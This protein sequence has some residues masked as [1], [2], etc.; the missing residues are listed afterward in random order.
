MSPA[1]LL[2]FEAANP[3]WSSNKEM[4][5]RRELQVTPPRYLQLLL[6]AADSTEG[7]LADPITARLVRSPGR[8]ARVAAQR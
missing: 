8:R 5:I 2:A 7:M 1:E 6:R 4:R 3:G